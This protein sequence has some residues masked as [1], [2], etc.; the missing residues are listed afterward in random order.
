[1]GKSVKKYN[2]VQKTIGLFHEGHFD[3]LIT[4]V[5]NN[6]NDDCIPFRCSSARTLVLYILS[7]KGGAPSEQCKIVN[8]W[9]HKVDQEAK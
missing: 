7:Y 4:G 6:I 5:T 1:M 9:I 3:L 8:E 2:E